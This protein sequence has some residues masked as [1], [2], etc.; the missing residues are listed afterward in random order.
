MCTQDPIFG[1]QVFILEKQFL[2]DQ[3]GHI[4]KQPNPSV[5]FHLNRISYPACQLP[6]NI[7]TQ[8]GPSVANAVYA[9]RIITPIRITSVVTTSIRSPLLRSRKSTARSTTRHFMLNLLNALFC[10]VS[11]VGIE[12]TTY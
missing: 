1:D 8:R 3:P 12:P 9:L 4:R 7:L 2:I 6:P 5:F 11:A 10:V